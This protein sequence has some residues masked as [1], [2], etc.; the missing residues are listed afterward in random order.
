MIS[1]L[2]T[3]STGFVG[4]F[5]TSTFKSDYNL[6]CYSLQS[7]SIE[8]L[9]LSGI[10]VVLHLAG[11][12]HQLKAV[13]QKIYYAVNY[14][15]TRQLANKAKQKGV[16]HFIFF[17]T[18]KVYGEY[19]EDREVWSEESECRPLSHY[20]KSK[21]M[22]EDVLLALADES[23]AVSIVRCP[24][25]YGRFVKGNLKALVSLIRKLPFIVF[26]NMTPKRGMIHLDNLAA[27]LRVIIEKSIG[28]VF[29]AYDGTDFSTSELLKIIATECGKKIVLF[30]CPEIF[31][32]L[33]GLVFREYFQRLF[34]PV[35]LDNILT[36]KKL[37]YLP[38]I[39]PRKGIK[40]ILEP[41][42]R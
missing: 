20:G 31:L 34:K 36:V 37:G 5:L 23:F 40:D 6:R 35:K 21:K 10:E 7:Q 26:P 38:V 11:I 42:N 19:T 2:V 9:N 28:G 3:G 32:A 22:A 18:V 13:D 12:A 16:G 14:E 27:M 33:F 17:S 29:L 30:H 39:T 25:I 15:L 4:S 8:E 41:E 1:V 24:L